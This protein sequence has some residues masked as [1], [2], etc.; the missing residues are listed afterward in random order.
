MKAAEPSPAVLQAL[1]TADGERGR[2]APGPSTVLPTSLPRA[3]SAAA[4][5]PQGSEHPARGRQRGRGEAQPSSALKSA[6][7][8]GAERPTTPGTSATAAPPPPPPAHL[9]SAAPGR[10]AAA[11]RGTPPAAA[12]RPAAAASP[13]RPPGAARLPSASAFPPGL[14]LRLPLPAPARAISVVRRASVQQLP[15]PRIAFSQPAWG[16]RASETLS[17]RPTSVARNRTPRPEQGEMQERIPRTPAQ[18]RCC[19]AL[20]ACRQ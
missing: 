2:R 18:S 10:G 7:R 16:I 4:S 1:R 3:A 19:L 5:A 11:Q 17:S 6:A 9:R 12:A 14:P 20:P 8:P 13:R 15:Q